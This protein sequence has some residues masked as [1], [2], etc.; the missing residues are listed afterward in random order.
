MSPFPYPPENPNIEKQIENT[1]K[2]ENLVQKGF[3]MPETIRELQY[4]VYNL[5]HSRNT[6]MAVFEAWALLEATISSRA[7]L[8]SGRKLKKGDDIS[9]KS[10][11]EKYLPNILREYD[12]DVD[13]V[14][15]EM[16]IIRKLRNEVTHHR[17]TPTI[18]EAKM[19]VSIIEKVHFIMDLAGAS[20][21]FKMG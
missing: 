21:L 3:L 15:A 4:I 8:E 10:I 7:T 5:E 11:C 6:R 20:E 12:C 18:E 13:G 1:K 16:E 9:A 2:I 17:K 14:I 19:T